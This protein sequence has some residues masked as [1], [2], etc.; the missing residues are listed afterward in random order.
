MF[1]SIV[2]GSTCCFCGFCLRWL[3][4]LLAFGGLCGYVLLALNVVLLVVLVDFDG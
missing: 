1:I 2:F 4:R 3:L